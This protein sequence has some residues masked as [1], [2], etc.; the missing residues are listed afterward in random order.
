MAS[1][2]TVRVSHPGDVEAVQNVANASWHA[3]YDDVLGPDVVDSV[4]DEWYTD[5]AIESGIKHD[6]QDFFVAVDDDE[7]IGYAHVGPHPPRRVHQIY[8]LYVHPDRWREGIGRQLLAEVEQ[9]LYDRDVTRYEAQV[10]ADN[11]VGVAFYEST[12]FER[13]DDAQREMAGETVQEY[14]FAKQL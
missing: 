14:V 9:A 7:V 5:D 10:L 13:V 2:V 12:G 4:L 3:A 1:D 8:R 11:V 6:A